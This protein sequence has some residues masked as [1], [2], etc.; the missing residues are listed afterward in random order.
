MELDLAEPVVN[1]QTVQDA[2]MLRLEGPTH[3]QDGLNEEGE[4]SESES[5]SG[6]DATGFTTDEDDEVIEIR[7]KYND[8]MSEVKKRGDIPLDN[9]IK[10]DGIH[11]TDPNSSDRALEGGDGVPYFDSDG[12]ASYDEDPDR[13]RNLLPAFGPAQQQHRIGE[14]PCL[15]V[16]PVL[17]R[18]PSE[19]SSS[20][21]SS[22]KKSNQINP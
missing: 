10:V 13:V 7:N 9:P 8:F 20:N 16:S 4:E 1:E 12:D 21:V 22:C 11:C 17:T 2:N 6:C 15:H 19:C 3:C 18:I 14:N 5:E